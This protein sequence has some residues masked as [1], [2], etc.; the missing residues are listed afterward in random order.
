MVPHKLGVRETGFPI[1]NRNA[2]L[3]LDEANEREA[4]YIRFNETVISSL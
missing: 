3:N 2:L 4:T 1:S